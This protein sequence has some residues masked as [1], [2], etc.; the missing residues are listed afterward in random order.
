MRKGFTPRLPDLLLL[1]ASGIWGFAFV[2]QRAGMEYQGPFGFNAIR[3]ALGGLSLIPL[4]KKD[5]LSARRSLLFGGGLC[6]SALFLAASLQQVGMES[7]SAGRGGFLTGLYILFVPLFSLLVAKRREKASIPA[8]LLALLGLY[9][10]TGGGVEK[11]FN[12]GDI[13]VFVSSLFWAV[14]ILLVDRFSRLFPPLK[15][16]IL[17]YSLCSALSLVSSL[18]FEKRLFPSSPQGWLPL[19]YGGF[20]SIGVAYTLQIVAQKR[21]PPSHASLILSLESPFALLGG[22]L[23]L[24]ESMGLRG[25]LGCALMLAAMIISSLNGGKPEELTREGIETKDQR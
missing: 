25:L 15:L 6:G 23:I 19:L 20:L 24:G 13:L 11:G 3:F 8:V 10:L 18:L 9:L 1:L 12:R 21:T 17:Q 22:W 14:H 7:T 2:A 5:H 16:A 4:L